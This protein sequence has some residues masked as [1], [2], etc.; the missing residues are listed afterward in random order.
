MMDVN[1]KNTLCV[2]AHGGI[3]MSTDG[4]NKPCCSILTPRNNQPPMWNENHGETDWWK[5]LRN[6]L[7]NGVKD[8]RCDKCWDQEAAG[9]RSMRLGSNERL[10]NDLV[11]EHEWSYVD[12]KLGSKCNLM[13]NMCDA[14]SSSLIAKEKWNNHKE[15]WWHKSGNSKDSKKKIWADYKQAGLTDELQW[16]QN[17]AFYEKIKENAKH[18]RTLKFTGGEPTLIPQVHEVMDYML[19]TGHSSHI[20]L[21]LTTNGTY[22]G[23]DIY[24]KMCQFKSA[25]INLSV[26][27]TDANYDYIRYP[28]TWKQWTRNTK[29]M[30]LFASDMNISYQFTVSVF[31]LF[32]IREFEKWVH[33]EGRRDLINYHSNFVYRPKAQNVRFL[34]DDTIQRA[35]DYLE[36]GDKIAKDAIKHITNGTTSP[37][38]MQWGILKQDTELKD[39][40]RPKRPNWDTIDNNMLRLKDLFHGR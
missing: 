25:K 33:E 12:L 26:D 39:R 4:M 20:E 40:L 21:S 6:N 9:I 2:Y 16:W 30:L 15:G 3:C 22:K 37:K 1:K 5:S 36:G 7:A 10:E 27:G 32:N 29:Q 35:V 18:I 38:E 28:H 19:E 13:C 11:T 8:Q 24:E 34:P 17:P 23:T 31:N 14:A